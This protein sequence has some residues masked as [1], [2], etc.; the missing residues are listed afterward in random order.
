[1]YAEAVETFVVEASG[2][3]QRVFAK[4]VR[5]YPVRVG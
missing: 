1:M 5:A 4:T 2:A 3:Y